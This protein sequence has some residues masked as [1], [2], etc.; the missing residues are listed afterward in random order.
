MQ[1]LGHEDRVAMTNRPGHNPTEASNE[2]I[3]LFLE[4]AL[5]PGQGPGG[6]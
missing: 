2:Q 6:R 3:Y 5:K 1:V 4:H